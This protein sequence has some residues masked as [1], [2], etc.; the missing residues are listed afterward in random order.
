MK[1]AVPHFGAQNESDFRLLR[2]AEFLGISCE[3]VALERTTDPA[4]FLSKSTP[5]QCSSIVVNPR[6]FEEWI[7]DKSLPSELV[8]L[9]LSQFKSI[10]VHGL[11]VDAFDGALVAALSRGSVKCIEAI[12]GGD[13]EYEIA[14]NSRDICE[15][16]SGISFGPADPNCDHVLSLS[17]AGPAVRRLISIG[18]QAFMA[19]VQVD[20]A[21]ILFIASEG[22]A[23]LDAQVGRS[24]LSEYFSRFVPIAMAL[25]HV[26]GDECW[27]PSLPHACIIIDDPLLRKNYGFLNFESLL[28]LTKTHKFH[29]AIAFIPHN[30]RRNSNSTL[31]LFR[32]NADRLSICF[33]GNDH[34]GAEFASVDASLLNTLLS[35]ADT[36]MSLHEKATGLKC[37]RVMVFPQG[38]FSLEAMRV[39]KSHSF[40]AAVNTVPHPAKEPVKLTLGELAQPAV[41]RYEGFPLF[42]RRPTC[43]TDLHDIAFS[44]F[45]GRPV[46]IVEHHDIFEQPQ[47]L[48][49]LVGRINSV[50]PEMR[51]SSLATAV[52]SSILTRKEWDGTLQVRAFAGNV[53]ISNDSKST[54]RCSVEWNNSDDGVA[55][56]HVRVDGTPCKDNEIDDRVLRV[57]VEMAPDCSRDVSLVFRNDL[58]TGERLGIRWKA[59]AFLRRR[60]SEFRDNYLS[61][62]QGLLEAAR[63]LQRRF[64]R[65]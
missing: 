13:L 39:L 60:L 7:G 21:D 6:V 18:G 8:D 25:R 49:D 38:N 37:D 24:P 29:T 50:V 9:L 58:G 48:L 43:E 34:T 63:T 35:V 22:V 32:E 36:R 17:G 11:R 51:W 47:T 65:I 33:H 42:T 62:N 44:V 61:K 30:F 27:R 4:V 19:Q 26:A 40:Y 1:L 45:W 57:N 10:V 15:A 56:D 64:L 59:R 23:N 52:S 12:S 41:F 14:K 54:Q 55:I 3:S 53:Q 20:Q 31:R 28:R 2:L 46:L 16:F 5:A